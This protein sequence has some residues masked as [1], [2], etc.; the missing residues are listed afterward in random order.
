MSLFP[1]C[2]P[3]YLRRVSSRAN[4]STIE[5]RVSAVLFACGPLFLSP[6]TFAIFVFTSA[7]IFVRLAKPTARIIASVFSLMIRHYQSLRSFF[8]ILALLRFASTGI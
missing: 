1:P 5:A 6:V 2:A 8:R 3:A 7:P 4:A